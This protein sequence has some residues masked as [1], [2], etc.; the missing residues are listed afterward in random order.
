MDSDNARKIILN[1]VIITEQTWSQ[2]GILWEDLDYIFVQ[3]GYEQGGF[4]TS[5]FTELLEKEQIFSINKIG[6]ILDH[7]EFNQTYNREFAGGLD[8]PFYKDLAGGKAELTGEKFFKLVKN[9]KSNKGMGYFMQLWRM[10]VCCNYLKNS[11]NS[12]FAHYLK[13]KYSN[14]KGI[15]NITDEK[16]LSISVNDWNKFKK[17]NTPWDELYGIGENVFDFIMGDLVDKQLNGYEFVK[18]SYKLDD[19]NIRFF[20]TTGICNNP[21]H[22]KIVKYLTSLE[23]PYTIRETNKGIYSYC[24]VTALKEVKNGIYKGKVK[25]HGFCRPEKCSECNVNN[26]CD[27]NFN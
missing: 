12:S 10:L 26:I 16:F 27:Q 1:A 18:N 5:K 19:S 22:D 2:Y 9:F 8:Q 7:F 13:K 4:N 17:E 11:Y 15:E 3:R 14:Y 23:L 24:S 20:K 25:N 6:H 21:K